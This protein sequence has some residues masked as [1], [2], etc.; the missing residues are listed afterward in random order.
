MTTATSL[1]DSLS[2]SIPKL[3]STG[4]NWAIFEIHF[5]DVI[6]AKRFWGHFDGTS[7]Q[8]VAISMITTDGTTMTDTAL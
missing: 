5:W 4:T 8:P 3:D 7:P 2:S 1:S 6:E